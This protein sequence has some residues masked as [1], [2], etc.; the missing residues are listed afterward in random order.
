MLYVEGLNKWSAHIQCRSSKGESD[1]MNGSVMPKPAILPE[2]EAVWHPNISK[3]EL[4]P[5]MSRN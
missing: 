3:K 2:L 5:S 1:F 4:S